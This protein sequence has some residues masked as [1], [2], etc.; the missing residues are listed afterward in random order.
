MSR[1]IIDEQDVYEVRV[2]NVVI[3][4]AVPA[5]DGTWLGAATKPPQILRHATRD[6]AV[7]AVRLAAQVFDA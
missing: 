3:A 2:N 1:Q 7:R 4:C 5:S 6:E